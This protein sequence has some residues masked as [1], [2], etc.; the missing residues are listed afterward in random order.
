MEIAGYGTTDMALNRVAGNGDET[1]LVKFENISRHNEAKSKEAG[2]PIHEMVTFI[3]IRTPGQR[4]E[5][6]KRAI[7]PADKLRF[8]EHWKAF[9]D[10][11]NIPQAEGTPLSEWAGVNAAQIE[12]FKYLH[13]TTVQQLVNVS[14]TNANNIR[15]FYAIK[16]KAIAYL[17]SALDNKAAEELEK[18]KKANSDLLERISALEAGA[19]KKEAPSKRVRPK[20]ISEAS[21]EQN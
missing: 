12:E 19:E 4:D 9:N 1:M 5:E 14:D 20:K 6:V 13:I 11:E 17:N 8:P 21:V 3:S 7:R 16:E 10:R 15:G 2:T 18:Q